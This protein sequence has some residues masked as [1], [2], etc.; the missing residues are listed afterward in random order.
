MVTTAAK[1]KVFIEETEPKPHVALTLT[2]HV[3]SNT[4]VGNV[5]N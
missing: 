5:S 2:F 4:F 1:V 3:S